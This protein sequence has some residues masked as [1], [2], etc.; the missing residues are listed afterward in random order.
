[1]QSDWGSGSCA[2]GAADMSEDDS[3]TGRP[4]EYAVG[5]SWE[6]LLRA[7]GG[8]TG[9]GAECKVSPTSARNWVIGKSSPDKRS[10]EL[11]EQAARRAGVASPFLEQP[12]LP[13]LPLGRQSK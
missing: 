12:P 7:Y 2:E 11:I 13:K 5:T 8:F 6:P 4:P 10:R 1:M 9:L 3:R